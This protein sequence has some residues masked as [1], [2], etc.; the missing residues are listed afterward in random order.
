MQN[1]IS[2]IIIKLPLD[3]ICTFSAQITCKYKNYIPSDSISCSE[4]DIW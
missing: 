1:N 2:H 4:N 3:N